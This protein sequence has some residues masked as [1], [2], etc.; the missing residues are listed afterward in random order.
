MH[1]N[2]LKSCDDIRVPR[3][4]FDYV[5]HK[6]DHVE[7]HGFADGSKDAGQLPG[8]GTSIYLGYGDVPPFRVTFC[9]K[10]CSLRVCFSSYPKLCSLRVYI[11][12]HFS[13][14]GRYFLFFISSKVLN[15][16]PTLNLISTIVSTTYPYLSSSIL[17]TPLNVALNIEPP[18]SDSSGETRRSSRKRTALVREM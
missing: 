18:A 13:T 4:I 6:S 7:L 16:S 14:Q 17:C 8:G 3:F 5:T 11:F 1:L 10:L 9:S 15:F 2:D 12:L